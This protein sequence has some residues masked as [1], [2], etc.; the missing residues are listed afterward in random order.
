M[1]SCLTCSF[2]LSVTQARRRHAVG[3]R[4]NLIFPTRREAYLSTADDKPIQHT[5]SEELRSFLFLT[6]V[7]APV[8]TGVIIAGFGFLV[9]M[10]QIISG[11]PTGG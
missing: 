9:W 2:F 8:V 4:A 1:R 5:R 10:A 7:M 11:P 3:A 6:V